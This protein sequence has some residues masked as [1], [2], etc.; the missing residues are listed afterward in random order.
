MSSCW[1]AIGPNQQ[2]MGGSFA[3]FWLVSLHHEWGI[4][5]G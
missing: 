4:M 1:L 5:H 2:P 3:T